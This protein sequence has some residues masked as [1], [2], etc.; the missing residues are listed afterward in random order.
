MHGSNRRNQVVIPVALAALYASLLLPCRTAWCD[1]QELDAAAETYTPTAENLAARRWFQDARFGVFIH[2]GVYSELGRGE[3]V[4]NNQKMTVDQYKP[5]AERFNPT[6]YDPAAWVAL[7]KKSGARYITITSKHHDGFALWD[8]KTSD[9]NVVDATPYGKDLLKPLAEACK[10]QGIKLF[11]YHSHLDWTHPDYFPRGRTGQHSG[12]P[13]DGNFDRYLDHMDAQLA[14]LLGGDYGDVAG[15]WFDGWWD[16][17]N[18]SPENP[19]ATHVDWRLGQTYRLIHGLQPAALVGNNHHVQP[20]PGED[21]QM[22][23]RDLPGENQGG[24]SAHAVIGDL[25]LETCDTINKSWGYNAS[26]HS[27][28]STRQLVHYLVKAAGRDANLLLN[29]GPKPD[30]TIQDEF[31]ERLLAM[32]KWLDVYGDSIYG[33][34]GGPVAPQAWGVT[35]RR[36]DAV[37]IHVLDP[38]KPG[39]DGWSKLAG[40]EKLSLK[41]LG[42]FDPSEKLEWRRGADGALEVRLKQADEPAIDT[43]LVGQL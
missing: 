18:R 35:T 19:R 14:E 37:Y 40:C 13:D 29:V 36:G 23:E 41:E 27:V 2:W 26:D 31:Q 12:R 33:T 42:Y 16:Q 25:P 39:P 1:E 8:S 43:L 9:W 38:P 11:F 3:W 5:L 22:F 15:I 4:M 21:F 32:G 28:K 7:V 34:R 30:G 17:L 20:F 10:A 24:H 6:K